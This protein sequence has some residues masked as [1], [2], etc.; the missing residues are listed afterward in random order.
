[1]SGRGLY[2]LVLY[3][4]SMNI[5]YSVYWGW[6]LLFH[7]RQRARWYARGQSVDA[8]VDAV[9]ADPLQSINRSGGDKDIYQDVG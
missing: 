6:Y 3:H 1:M 9:D 2:S 8:H 7:A 5:W 4:I